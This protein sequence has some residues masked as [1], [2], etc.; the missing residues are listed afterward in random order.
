MLYINVVDT[1]STAE[2]CVHIDSAAAQRGPTWPIVDPVA[3]KYML[4]E[5]KDYFEDFGCFYTKYNITVL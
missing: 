5:Y 4:H 2:N 1:V 3:Q